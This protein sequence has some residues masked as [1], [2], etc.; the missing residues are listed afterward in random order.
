MVMRIGLV[1]PY[2][3]TKGGGV[4]EGVLAIQHELAERGH[5]AKIIT[6][7]PKDTD[8]ADWPQ[9]HFIGSGADIRS[10]FATTAQ[11]SMKIKTEEIE[12]LL[13]SEQFDVLHFHEPWVPMLS[14]QLLS[15]SNTVN[16][17]T[18]HARLPD[19]LM[20]KTVETV[21]T[22]YTKPLIRYL[23]VITAVSDAAAEYVTTLTNHQINIVP[24]GINLKKYKLTRKKSDVPQILYI[25][26]L[27]KRKGVRYLLDAFAQVQQSLPDARLIIAGDGPDRE[28]LQRYAKTLGLK[29]VEFLGYIDESKKLEL[30]ASADVF[31]SPA[32]YGESFGIVLL[33]AMAAGIPIVA[34][35]NPGYRAVMKERGTLSLV[36][37]RQSDE[38]GRRLVLLLTD[39]G[40]RKLW[41]DWAKE[42]VQQFDYPKIVDMYEKLYE[43]MAK[44]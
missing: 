24:N 40:V 34:G 2:N 22:P 27:E 4:Q 15:R 30:L 31:C 9:V 38:F 5:M 3:I 13:E 41:G 23:D 36:N 8:P 37:P 12:N 10:P 20:S 6:F 32:L 43:S 42:Y 26:R 17:G 7:L 44:T 19:T 16:I 28:K 35:D 33:E 14:R 1:C 18:F 11:V 29:H 39:E 21:I 25:G